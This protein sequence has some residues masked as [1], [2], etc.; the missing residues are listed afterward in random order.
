[1]IDLI[2]HLLRAPQTVKGSTLTLPAGP[3]VWAHGY[4][5]NT[6][7][8][9]SE[10]VGIP[11]GGLMYDDGAAAILH[12][13]DKLVTFDITGRE[14]HPWRME[15]YGA[16]GTVF[17]GLAPPSDRRYVHNPYGPYQPGW[18]DWQAIPLPGIDPTYRDEMAQMLARVRSWGID[19]DQGIADAAAVT[20]I[21]DQIFARSR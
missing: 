3:L 5:T 18:H 13:D 21:L 16:N 9:E 20:T 10:T 8:V 1:M 4:K 12:S 6:L 2:I 17:A 14:A 11:L 15:F 19:N 7:L